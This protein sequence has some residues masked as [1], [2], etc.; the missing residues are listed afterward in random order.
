MQYRIAD[1][2][3]DLWIPVA[4]SAQL[5]L[6]SIRIYSR[7]G[8]QEYSCT[9]SCKGRDGKMD[10]Q[11]VNPGVYVYHLVYRD[12]HGDRKEFNGEFTLLR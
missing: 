5:N 7:W 10:D 1:G 9:S 8:D 11:A 3:N 6:I 4:S 2:I 12:G